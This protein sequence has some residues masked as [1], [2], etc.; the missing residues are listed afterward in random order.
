MR[1]HQG[2]STVKQLLK[3]VMMM[4]MMASG[5]DLGTNSRF[6]LCKGLHIHDLQT[7]PPGPL[8]TVSCPQKFLHINLTIFN[9]A[10]RAAHV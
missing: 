9:V 3:V 8:Q 6:C 10:L 7:P 5:R 2:Q 1:M 4:M